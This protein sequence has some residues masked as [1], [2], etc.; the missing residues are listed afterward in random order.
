MVK[1]GEAW[2]VYLFSKF[3]EQLGFEKITQIQSI[4]PDCTALK[5][6]KEVSIEF[7]TLS[8]HLGNHLKVD[9]FNI[10]PTF[11]D[12][13]ETDTEITLTHKYSV[14]PN[15]P[16]IF[17]NQDYFLSRTTPYNAYWELKRKCLNLDYCIAWKV[18]DNDRKLPHYAKTQ[19]IE[20]RTHPVIQ[21]F[22]KANNIEL[23]KVN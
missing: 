10:T 5:Q 3:H 22:L 19:F 6:G 7:E 14:F 13:K 2:V 4:F 8:S 16:L 21:Q 15:K 9:P 20:L 1:I 23:E 11:Y 18:S 12:V 17:S